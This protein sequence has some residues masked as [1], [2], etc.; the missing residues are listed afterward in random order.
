MATE[1]SIDARVGAVRR[2]NRFYT[3]QIG[4]L[5]EGLLDSPFSLSEI[6]VLYELAQRDGLTA[7]QL[8]GELGLDAGYLSRMLRSFD[9]RGLI[10]KKTSQ[11]DGRQSHLSLTE[12]GRVGLAPLDERAGREVAALL[13]K[14]SSAEQ[15]RLLESM[16]TI[17]GLLGG[18][19]KDPY[20]L[21]CHRPGDMGWVIHRHGVLYSQECG[22]DERFE[23]LVAE[24]VAKFIRQYNPQF[25]RCW[26]VEKDADIIGCVFLVRQSK[27]VAKLRLLLVEPRARGLGL[28]S[29]LVEECVRFARQANYRKIILWTNSVLHAARHIYEKAGFGLVLEEPHHS[30][31]HDLVGQTWELK[32]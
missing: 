2:F 31:G 6:R 10:D 7:T 4:L 13:N 26:I 18:Q 32:L 25:E 3:Q 21:R 1:N 22:W 20:L 15:A 5:N 30:F 29:R 19:Q 24:I 28:G 11:A 16:Q 12:Q 9:K 27:T 23:A 17:E 14:L 8:S